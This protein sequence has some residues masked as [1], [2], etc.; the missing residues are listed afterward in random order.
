[1]LILFEKR[2]LLTRNLKSGQRG[3]KV[4]F[5]ANK[6]TWRVSHIDF[7]AIRSVEGEGIGGNR[8]IKLLEFLTKVIDIG[9]T[10]NSGLELV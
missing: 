7:N 5:P 6:Q 3:G 1:L 8:K 9:T 2:P 4:E 10:I